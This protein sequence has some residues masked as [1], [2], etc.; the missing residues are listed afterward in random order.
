V[1]RKRGAFV[2]DNLQADLIFYETGMAPAEWDAIARFRDVN[3]GG[4]AVLVTVN[5]PETSPRVRT[6]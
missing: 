3:G 5:K 1:A 6:P 4:A 2:A